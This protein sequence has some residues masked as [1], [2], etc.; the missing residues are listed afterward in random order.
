MHCMLG[1]E[2]CVGKQE[3]KIRINGFSISSQVVA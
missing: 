1:P 3:D 2:I